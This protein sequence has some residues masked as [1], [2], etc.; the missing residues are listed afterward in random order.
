MADQKGD[1]NGRELARLLMESKKV[2]AALDLEKADY[3]AW[4]HRQSRHE[5]HEQYV[6]DAKSR[7]LALGVA[8]DSGAALLWQADLPLT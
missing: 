6:A 3:K 4:L 5:E 7:I 8:V 2:Q 1:L